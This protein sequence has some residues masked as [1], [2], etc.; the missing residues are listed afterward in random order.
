MTTNTD[1]IDLTLIDQLL[2]DYQ[3]P[4]DI[5]GENGILKQF[6]KAILERA[7][8]AELT[9]HLGYE[10]HDPE[11]YNSGNSRN[12]TGQKKLKGDFGE[13]PI[14]VPRD[15]Q[16]T[17]EPQ[18]VAKGQTRFDGFDDKIISLYARGL[19]TREIQAH[20]EE[21]Y[22]VEVSPALISKVTDAVADEVKAWQSRPLDS[23]YPILYLDALQV[24]IRDGARGRQQ[25]D[26]SRHWRAAF[27]LQGSL[28]DVGGAD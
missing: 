8:Q 1:R 7:M 10:K 21:I 5:L 2:K 23:F 26:L 25:G 17:F 28:R 22:K 11:G 18:I 12:G 27:R 14:E 16:A 13:L 20:L 3:K 15:R 24:K 19:S 6:T 9:H 4:E